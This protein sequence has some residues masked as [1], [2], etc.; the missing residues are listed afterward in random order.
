MG[1]GFAGSGGSGREHCC[2][3][4]VVAA[5][6]VVGCLGKEGQDHSPHRRSIPL[7]RL[8][9]RGP[10][11][12]CLALVAPAWSAESGSLDRVGWSPLSCYGC[13]IIWG[14]A[15]K[16]S[17]VHGATRWR[18]LRPDTRIR[19]SPHNLPMSRPS[20][21][22]SACVGSHQHGAIKTQIGVIQL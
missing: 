5:S 20:W 13:G 2:V 18:L 11:G 6:A 21:P 10:W 1:G 22:P 19:M 16:L 12:R 17:W 9:C 4:N 14:V 7:L 8:L 15:V 3:H